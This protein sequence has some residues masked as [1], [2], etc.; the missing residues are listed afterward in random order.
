MNTLKPVY[1]AIEDIA[2]DSSRLSKEAKIKKYL[3]LPYFRE[4]VKYAYD[5]NKKY[6]TTTVEFIKDHGYDLD[7]KT[8]F[9]YL[10]YLSKLRGATDEMKYNLSVLSSM[11]E[12]TNILVNRIINKD[13]KCGA[14]EGSF[15]K[16]IKDLPVFE[17]MTCIKNIPQFLK[18]AKNR[19][20]YWSKKKDGV[21]II[22][23]IDEDKV[24]AHT[25]R[26]GLE[27]INFSIFDKELIQFANILHTHFD[28]EYPIRID[29]EAISAGNNF[30]KV[31]TQIKRLN[32]ADM[33]S[34]KLH[35][36]DIPCSRSFNK[37]YEMIEYVF[38]LFK[39]D[40]L[41][42]VEHVLCKYNED[43]LKDLAKEMYLNGD[44]GVD[45]G[46][47][48]KIYDSPYEYKEHS[49]W[50]CKV[51]PTD[52]LDLPVIGFEFGT[53]GSR[54]EDVVGKLIV[55]FR[56]VEVRVGSGLSDEQRV[57]FLDNLPSLIEVEFKEITKDNSLREPIFKRVR[58]DKLIHD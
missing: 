35:I 50:W 33:S 39:F 9:N 13:L 4:V 19:E 43:Q 32:N 57:E 24:L 53:P 12:E 45:E 28:L 14:S 6:N 16:F 42:L 2:S 10:D 40:T 25:S 54:L 17:I 31:M 30:N 26:S 22:C 7:T 47:V 36:F 37:R 46:I 38:N 3:D 29:G 20:Y 58:D 56:G 1:E 41:K 48:C 11:D 52:T 15:S 49:K 18:L 5:F 8:L 44:K 51:K 34:F 21:R 27:Y 23:T 55:D